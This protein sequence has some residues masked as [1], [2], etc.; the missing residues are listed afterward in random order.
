MHAQ[1]KPRIR[2]QL[3]QMATGWRRMA[4]RPPFQ[5]V[6]FLLAMVLFNWPYLHDRLWPKEK[7][8]AYIFAA[9]GAVVVLLIIIGLSVSRRVD[10]T[11][12]E[13]KPPRPRPGPKD[14]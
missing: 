1:R 3:R 14:R 12:K 13:H 9:W 2:D 6:V 10:E 7:L 11:D 4:G 5:G 8:Y